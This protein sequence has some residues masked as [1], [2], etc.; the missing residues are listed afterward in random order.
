MTSSN[1]TINDRSRT[2]TCF[3][4]GIN[5]QQHM[6]YL[7]KIGS[8]HVRRLIIS[9]LIFTLVLY[10]FWGLDQGQKYELKPFEKQLLKANV[11]T[12]ST[13]HRLHS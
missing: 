5:Y 7:R 11:N 1:L 12:K 6:Y 2:I 4:S 9:R 3:E 10:I 8:C 13:L